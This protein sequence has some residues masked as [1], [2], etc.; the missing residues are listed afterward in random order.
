MR[1]M[2]LAAGLGTRL[3]PLTDSTPKALITIKGHT[4][5]ELQIKKLRAEGFDQILINVHHFANQVKNYLKQNN[6]F[7]CTIEI[8][9]ESELLLDTGGAIK[10]A[11][12]FFS[13]GKPYLVYNVDILS[14]I[15]LG[16][17]MNIHLV[18]SSI[19]TLAVQDRVSS[20]KFLFDESMI[21]N[22]WMNEK[23][24]EKNIV[25]NNQSELFPYAFSGVQIVD[26]KIFKYFP[27]KD[28]F[29]LIELYLSVAKEEKIIG[30]VH[31]EDEWID[32]GKME[33]VSKAEKVFVKIRS[34]YPV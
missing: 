28:V 22:G 10:K 32:L 8:S 13:D 24:E 1:A 27:D 20:R 4:L 12:Y 6:Y 21:L 9:D 31:N 19:A 5:L 16:K 18:S 23:T 3:K 25:K 15:N 11:A 17:L 26:P 30:Y 14:N 2:I 34:T 7:D 33:N 29:S